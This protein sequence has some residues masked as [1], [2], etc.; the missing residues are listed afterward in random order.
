MAVEHASSAGATRIHR[1][2]LEIGKMAGVIPEALHFAHEA[3]T[4]DTLAAGST[5]EIE[6]APIRCFCDSCQTEFTP[7][8]PVFRCPQCRSL[9][10]D[11]RSG[12]QLHI[13]DME[14]S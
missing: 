11:I 10:S 7:E 2:R 8:S 6:H 9:S 12:R 13:I 3:V 4:E 5:L 1:I 14:I